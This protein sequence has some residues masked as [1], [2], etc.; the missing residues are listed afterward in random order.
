M[1]GGWC[2]RDYVLSALAPN[3]AIVGSPIMFLI[4]GASLAVLG[5]GGDLAESVLKRNAHQKDSSLWLPGLGGMLDVLD[6]V[7][8]TAP[9]ALL[10]WT[11]GWLISA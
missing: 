8:A 3:V 6:S 9:L 1:A 7:L 2:L 11:S 4:F 10:W 5:L